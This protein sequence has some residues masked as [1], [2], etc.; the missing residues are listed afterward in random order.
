MY[1]KTLKNKYNIVIKN[2]ELSSDDIDEKIE[3]ISNLTYF[4]CMNENN[5]GFLEK[6]IGNSD[7]IDKNLKHK[8]YIKII[9]LCKNNE[10][11]DNNNTNSKEETEQKKKKWKEIIKF[12][13]GLYSQSISSKN[14]NNFIEFLVNLKEE[15]SNDLIENLNTKYIITKNEFYSTTDNLNIQLLILIKNKLNIKNENQYIEKNISVIKEIYKEIDEQEIKYND[16]LYFF[17]SSS[18]KNILIEKLNILLLLEEN[19]IN[20]EEIY[21]NLRKYY[22]DMNDMLLELTN[23]KKILELYHKEL[24]KD[25]ILDINIYLDSL[26]KGTYKSFYS[27]KLKIKNILY[28]TEEI[29]EK[30]Y[31]IKDSKI[32]RIFY[33]KKKDIKEIK[34]SKSLFNEAYDQFN[35]FKIEIA[36]KGADLINNSSSKGEI[37]NII[38]QNYYL[39]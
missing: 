35:Q 5:L 20:P 26:V 12:L 9:N 25:K 17:G 32:F 33:I 1:L 11:K 4:I 28:E 29:F 37:F 18:E 3:S 6:I 34:D 31:K 38:E 27:K 2:L 36:A 30:V 21:D 13:S 15:D 24:E 19:D 22:K 14:L 23:K 16:L 39:W 8:I 10:K 7:I